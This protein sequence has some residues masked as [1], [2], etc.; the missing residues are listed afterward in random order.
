MHASRFEISFKS[1]SSIDFSNSCISL[2]LISIFA[3]KWLPTNVNFPFHNSPLFFFYF[4]LRLRVEASNFIKQLSLKSILFSY[5][6]LSA[7]FNGAFLGIKIIFFLKVFG[8]F[9]N[10]DSTL[11]IKIQICLNCHLNPI[12]NSQWVHHFINYQL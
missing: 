11:K 8:I 2:Y 7:K 10:Y 6:L 5:S 9:L 1:C 3:C 12:W 4:G